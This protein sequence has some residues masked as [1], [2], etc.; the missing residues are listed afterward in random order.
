VD[1]ARWPLTAAGLKALDADEIAGGFAE[2][3]GAQN[4]P[5]MSN[6]LDKVKVQ[7]HVCGYDQ[8]TMDLL[9]NDLKLNAGHKPIIVEWSLAG[10]LPG[11]EA[12]VHFH[13]STCGGI[14]TGPKGDGVG[15]GY[16]WCDGDNRMDDPNGV[17][18]PPVMYTWQQIMAA[19]PVGYIVIN[20]GPVGAPPA[21]APVNYE[22]KYNA[23]KAAI[24]AVLGA[25]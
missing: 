9:H 17:P 14:D 18:R 16:L 4:I 25:N 20:E 3:N 22:A 10:N 2:S 19:A 21:P 13:Y 6:Y 7:H 15:G 11:D 1:G 24:Q 12:G 23:L 5:S 8:F